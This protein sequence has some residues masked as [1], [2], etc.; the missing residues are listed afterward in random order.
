MNSNLADGVKLEVLRELFQ[1]LDLAPRVGDRPSPARA[2]PR[3]RVTGRAGPADEGGLRLRSRVPHRLPAR[4]QHVLAVLGVLQMEKVGVLCN[5]I[6]SFEFGNHSTRFQA[7]E[8]MP[9][10]IDST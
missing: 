8:P 2:R 1:P 6:M 9:D 4:R 3:R 5:S 10:W 7:F